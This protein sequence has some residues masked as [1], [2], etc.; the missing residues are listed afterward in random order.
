[1]LPAFSEESVLMPLL[2]DEHLSLF[3]SVDFNDGTKQELSLVDAMV[4][5]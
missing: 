5:P 3:V 1:M 4:A 2:L